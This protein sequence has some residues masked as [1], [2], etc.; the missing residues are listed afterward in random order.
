MPDPVLIDEFHVSLFLSDGATP[1]VVD[2]ARAAL[3][4][5]QFLDTVRNAVR[6]V[7]DANPAT[8]VLSANV[9]W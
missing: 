7:L 3:D 5:P 4:D 9:D 8:I 6:R 2:A 1:S